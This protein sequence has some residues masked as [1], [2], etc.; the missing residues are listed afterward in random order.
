MLTL[1][2]LKEMKP[3]TIFAKGFFIDS[4]E[5]V[6]VANTGKLCKFVAVRGDIHDW[7]IYT[8]NPHDP[9]SD[10]NDVAEYGDKLHN[11]NYVKKL[12]KCD[13]EALKM[14]RH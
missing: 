12:V 10:M 7:T 3:G 6:N 1:Q 14:Y 2:Q 5:A 13:D 8:D 4:P 9:R 11:L